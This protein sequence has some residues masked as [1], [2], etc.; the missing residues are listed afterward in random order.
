M[1]AVASTQSSETTIHTLCIHVRIPCMHVVNTGPLGDGEDKKGNL[2][3][4]TW[5]H[6]TTYSV[7]LHLQADRLIWCWS[8][9]PF[10]LQSYESTQAYAP[11]CSRAISEKSANQRRTVY[12]PPFL[13]VS[14][15]A[16]LSEE[17]M[18]RQSRR[19]VSKDIPAIHIAKLP[20]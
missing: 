5:I 8:I 14:C 16:L 19:I 10:A 7:R 12:C 15:P 6:A 4:A 17:M 20:L 18:R 11:R 3:S 2:F 1:R 9:L 13:A